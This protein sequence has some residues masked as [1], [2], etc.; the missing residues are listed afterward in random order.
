VEALTRATT[1]LPPGLLA[2]TLLLTACSWQD[3][4]RPTAADTLPPDPT[5]RQS[6]GHYESRLAEL[7]LRLRYY[8]LTGVRREQP[9]I[10]REM[11]VM[12]DSIR[13]EILVVDRDHGRHNLWSLDAHDFTLHWKTPLEA[14]VNFRPMATGNY[15]FLM[16]A[17]GEYQAYDRVSAPRAGESRLASRGRFMSDLFPSAQPAAND[18]HLFVPSASTNS[19]RGLSMMHNPRGEGAETWS[20]PRPG[21]YTERRFQQIRQTPVADTETVVFVNNNNYLYMIDAQTGDFRAQADLRGNSRTPPVLKDDLVFVGSDSGQLFAWQKSGEAAWVLTA[22]GLPY[23]EIFVMDRW[24]FVRT[25]EV[26]DSG[27]GVATRPGRLSAYRYEL[28]DIPGDRPVFRLVDGDPSTPHVVDPIWS[29]ADVNQRVLT[30]H[31]GRLYVLYEQRERFLHPREVM[32]LRNEGRIAND[33]DETRLV[34][35][36]LRVLDVNTGTLMRP[37]WDVDLSDFHTVRGSM[38]EHDRAIYLATEDGYLFKA[39]GDTRRRSAGGR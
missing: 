37:E 25:L 3:Q 16:N 6:A 9:V 39:F 27:N 17:Q 5:T 19:M 10:V 18:T 21:A 38:H 11:H 34:S 36:R 2:L 30:L 20:F 14:R 23:G 26:Y 15:V 32:R 1:C 13:D 22:S 33:D 29:E 35:R 28:V 24:V 8:D 4:A 7:P 12:H 31:D